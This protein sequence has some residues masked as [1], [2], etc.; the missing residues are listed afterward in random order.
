MNNAVQFTRTLL[1]SY[2]S[3]SR[4]FEPEQIQTRF[5]VYRKT[6]VQFLVSV[7]RFS[8]VTVTPQM[9][10]THLHINSALMIRT[11]G[12]SKDIF[13]LN[14]CGSVHHA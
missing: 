11:S 12:R 5:L 8:A 1:L 7:L 6:L 10:D 14:I 4:G 3:R 13:E 2:I 9:L